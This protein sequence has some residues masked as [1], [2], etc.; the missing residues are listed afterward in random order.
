M[1]PEVQGRGTTFKGLYDYSKCSVTM[2]AVFDLA[3]GKNSMC[4]R[5]EAEIE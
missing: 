3:E 5:I 4:K 2:T 1:E